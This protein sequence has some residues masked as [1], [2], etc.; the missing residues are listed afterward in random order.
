MDNTKTDINEV[1]SINAKNN[2]MIGLDNNN[3]DDTPNKF[4]YITPIK[5]SKPE[6][7]STFDNTNSFSIL[8]TI[9]KDELNELL[10]EF[11]ET[12]TKETETITKKEELK[13]PPFSSSSIKHA[14]SSVK[15][16]K[17][18]VK[19][20]LV[21]G[22]KIK[23]AFN[24]P[25]PS[26]VIKILNKRRC[27]KGQ[28]DMIFFC[29]YHNY[30]KI[31]ND[32]SSYYKEDINITINPL[33]TIPLEVITQPETLLNLKF[34]GS[35]KR[36]V[37]INYKNDKKP[38]ILLNKLSDNLKK[39]LYPFQ[40]Q[41][42]DYSIRKNCRLIIGDDMGLGKTIEAISL[43]SLYV[44][45]WPLLIICPSSIKLY[46]KEQ[47]IKYLKPLMP[48]IEH[49]IHIIST[50]KDI[51]PKLKLS[52]LKNDTT[53]PIY[54]ISYELC[55]KNIAVIDSEEKFSDINFIICDEAHYLKNKDSQRTKSLFPYIQK[56]KRIL[57]LTG[58]P[59]I[60]RP[61]DAFILL[62]IIRPDIFKAFKPYGDRYCN[63]TKGMF[64][65]DYG[66][67][68]NIDE[69]KYIMKSFMIRRMKN[70]VISE[71][72]VKHRQ[73]I[74]ITS[75][76]TYHSQILFL[77]SKSNISELFKNNNENNIDNNI[78][79]LSTNIS[80]S[81]KVDMTNPFCCFAKAFYLTAQS[82]INSII[83]YVSYVISKQCKCIF[84]AYHQFILD[85]IEEEVKSSKVKYI[86]I[87]STV[88]P[89]KRNELIKQYEN[90]SEYFIAIL[91]LTSSS[92]GFS[93]S[94]CSNIVFCEPHYRKE[95][96]LQG[97]DRC[98]R[99]GQK[100]ANVNIHYLYARGTVD[101]IL[102]PKTGFENDSLVNVTKT[103]KGELNINNNLSSNKGTLDSFFKTVNLHDN[104]KKRNLCSEMEQFSISLNKEEENK[105]KYEEKTKKI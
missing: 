11:L 80:P 22:N 44:E 49:Y 66:G 15:I 19:F 76:N 51:A 2:E 77:V 20:Q 14:N 29:S 69:F 40:M 72:P 38:S 56:A 75:D 6:I 71:L 64:K 52:S 70:E 9:D 5:K 36:F 30:N 102:Y 32:L 93:L 18:V 34:K 53:K 7:Q 33:T 84:F 105:M 24:N 83:D 28:N 78:D 13:S 73:R 67:K 46:W 94:S 101:D 57:L 100:C 99:I 61:V 4:K 8:D 62:K 17:T 95:I 54:I 23:I 91:S 58:T 103:G 10:S 48:N 50:S 37:K 68:D 87:D 65:I 16:S 63:P 85:S 21:E 43:S 89:D 3:N 81:T 92:M 82:K 39:T 1:T 86:R 90:D 12:S 55:A 96:I 60:Q 104:I 88:L 79:K 41:C 27:V 26:D 31:H 47:L 35:N 42:I 59:L 74:L 45:D 25:P 98:H 97:E